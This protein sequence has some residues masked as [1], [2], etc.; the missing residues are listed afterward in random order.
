M[1]ALNCLCG[2]TACAPEE[3]TDHLH[4]AFLRNDDTGHDGLRHA[5]AAIDTAAS[6]HPP[7]R[8]ECLCGFTTASIAEL[9]DHLLRAFTPAD[10]TAEDGTRHSHVH[11]RPYPSNA[12]DQTR[13]RQPTTEAFGSGATKR[14]GSAVG[15]PVPPPGGEPAPS[16][17]PG[18][19]CRP[20]PVKVFA[21][22]KVF[23]IFRGQS[24]D[25]SARASSV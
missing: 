9:D 1:I 6:G 7:S 5:E 19:F 8:V 24:D 22:R 14:D 2:F 3:F 25:S 11:D 15:W 18:D 16:S 21:T 13:A 17:S 4:E 12:P 20:S 10:Q 23:A